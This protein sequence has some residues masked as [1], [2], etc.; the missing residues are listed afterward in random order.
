[1][2]GPGGNGRARSSAEHARRSARLGFDEE[3]ISFES[4][5]TGRLGVGS[6]SARAEPAEP[7]ASPR[8]AVR[9]QGTPRPEFIDRPTQ[10]VPSLQSGSLDGPTLDQ[11][12]PTSRREDAPLDRDATER[13]LLEAIAAGDES[14]RLRYADWLEERSEHARAGFLRLEHLVSRLSPGDPRF[15]ACT[16]QLRELVQHIDLDWR[17]RVA[18]PKI[19]GCPADAFRCPRRWDALARTDRE[20]VRYCSLCVKHVFYFESVD[21]AREAARQGQCVAIDLGS[22]RWEHDLVDIGTRCRCCA[23]RIVATAQFCPH[24]GDSMRDSIEIEVD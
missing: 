5:P 8:A 18:R 10:L 13:G 14:C 11:A 17:A 1:M 22:E 9:A 6:V 7:A 21:D 15:E 4:W 24:C 2:R 19:E 16:R 3:L 20:T 23:R 12:I